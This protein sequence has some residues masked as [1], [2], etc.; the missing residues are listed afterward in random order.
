MSGDGREMGS[1]ALELYTE[2]KCVWI[3]LD[4]PE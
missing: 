4:E 3:N 2:V 1:Y